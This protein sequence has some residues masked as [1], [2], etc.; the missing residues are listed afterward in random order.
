MKMML[1]YL[2]LTCNKSIELNELMHI[3]CSQMMTIILFHDKQN[4]DTLNSIRAKSTLMTP[5]Y[6]YDCLNLNNLRQQP[7]FV[8]NFNEIVQAVKN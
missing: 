4:Y 1:T 3:K 7:Y 6:K 8:D 5:E 2:T